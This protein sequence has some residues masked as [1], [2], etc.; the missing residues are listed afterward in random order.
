MKKQY[1]S[2]MVAGQFHHRQVRL[3]QDPAHEVAKVTIAYLS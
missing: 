2:F 3:A 1:F